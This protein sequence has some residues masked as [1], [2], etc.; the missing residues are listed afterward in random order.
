MDYNLEERTAKL[1]EEVIEFVKISESCNE[2][3]KNYK[4]KNCY[5]G[6]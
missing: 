1:G 5:E 6:T 3:I 2:K 4:I